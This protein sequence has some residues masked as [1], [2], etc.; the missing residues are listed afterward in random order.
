LLQSA[1]QVA[2]AAVVEALAVLVDSG[3]VLTA[4]H[5]STMAT[6]SAA[7]KNLLPARF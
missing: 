5:I 2:D 4:T 7:Q 1:T 3:V 6:I